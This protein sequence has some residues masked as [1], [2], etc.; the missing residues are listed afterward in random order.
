[1]H[2]VSHFKILYL[3]FYMGVKMSLTLRKQHRLRAFENRVPRRMYGPKT[4]VVTGECRTLHGEEICN[5]FFTHS[6]V[7]GVA[8]G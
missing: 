2:S 8:I 4:A 7:R 3:L 5:V 6:G 1:M